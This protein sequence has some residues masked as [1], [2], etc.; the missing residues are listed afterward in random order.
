MMVMH[1]FQYVSKQ[2]MQLFT[3]LLS[4]IWTVSSKSPPKHNVIVPSSVLLIAKQNIAKKLLVH[5]LKHMKLSSLKLPVFIK[6]VLI[7]F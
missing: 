1:Y 7:A 2:K 6:I 4:I 3:G 5:Y